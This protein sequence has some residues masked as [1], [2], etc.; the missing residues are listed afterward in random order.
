MSEVQLIKMAGGN[1]RAAHQSDQDSVQ[2]IK[3][4]A[5]VLANIVQ[6]RWAKAH[7]E[8]HEAG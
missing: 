1:F 7:V 5:L 2:K 4:G 8:N 6:P 3:N